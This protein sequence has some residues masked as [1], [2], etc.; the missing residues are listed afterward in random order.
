MITTSALRPFAPCIVVSVT[1]PVFLGGFVSPTNVIAPTTALKKSDFRDDT[2]SLFS[3]S[4]R[5]GSN[6]L[7]NSSRLSAESPMTVSTR[8]IQ[9]RKPSSSL[10]DKSRPVATI[11]SNSVRSELSP[12]PKNAVGFSRRECNASVI[13]LLLSRLM[14]VLLQCGRFQ[15]HW[16]KVRAELERLSHLYGLLQPATPR[17]Q[18]I[19]ILSAILVR[20]VLAACLGR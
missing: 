6:T 3:N 2:S 5:S 13:V 10:G 11:A 12:T 9:F 17:G 8:S 20:F 18:G 16:L 19:R 15:F 1:S 14:R 7:S 4:S